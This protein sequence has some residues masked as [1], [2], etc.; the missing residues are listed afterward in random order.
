MSDR[1]DNIP[2]LIERLGSLLSLLDDNGHPIAA[3]KVEEAIFA[4]KN[5]LA[6]EQLLTKSYPGS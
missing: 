5:E 1:E 6:Q 2:A 4:L 3:I